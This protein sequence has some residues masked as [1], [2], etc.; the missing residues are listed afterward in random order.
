M[1]LVV[2]LL[3]GMCRL[4]VRVEN[5]RDSVELD[6]QPSLARLNFPAAALPAIVKQVAAAV[7]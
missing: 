7:R 6:K 4:I 1:S 3:F 5:F 2:G